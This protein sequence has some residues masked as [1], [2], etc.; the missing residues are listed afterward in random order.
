MRRKRSRGSD[1][2]YITAGR[3]SLLG[4]DTMNEISG[5]IS[6]V[7]FP[8][9]MCLVLIYFQYTSI[10]KMTEALDELKLVITQLMTKME[11]K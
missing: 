2:S 5:L 9:V 4:G 3:F 11:D 1:L 10:N 7:G 8:I 6:T